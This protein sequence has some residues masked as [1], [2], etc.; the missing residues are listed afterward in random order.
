[1][2]GIHA[3]RPEQPDTAYVLRI[4]GSL[5]IVR[6]AGR[7]LPDEILLVRRVSDVTSMLGSEEYRFFPRM[8]PL[9][10]AGYGKRA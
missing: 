10:H 8:R 9:P 2:W 4:P 6:P 7:L 3:D 1:M 5:P